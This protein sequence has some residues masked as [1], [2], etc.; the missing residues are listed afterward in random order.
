MPV[1]K[2]IKPVAQNRKA[3]H[4]YFI[5]DTY[6]CGIELVGTEVKSIR[7]GKV[8]L[9]DCYAQV[10]DGQMYVIGMHISPYEQGNIYNRDP[11]RSRRLLLHK[12]EIRKLQ[13]LS[14]S[15][16][17]PRAKSCTISAAPWRS[18]TPN[19][20]WTAGCG[21]RNGKTTGPDRPNIWGRT[22]FRRGSWR[23][24]KRAEDPCFDKNG[25]LKFNWQI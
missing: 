21:C 9:K 14:Q 19:G 17:W 7:A 1:Q 23:P 24:D 22:W 13:A 5:E 3:R 16:R 20:I 25:K 15:W 2:G 12:R 18:G 4:D 10:K 11:F 8:N 6:E